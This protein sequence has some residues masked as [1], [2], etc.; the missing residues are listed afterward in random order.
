MPGYNITYLLTA[1]LQSYLPP[2]HPSPLP[3]P[4]AKKANENFQWYERKISM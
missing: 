2:L 1:Q 4:P 3:L